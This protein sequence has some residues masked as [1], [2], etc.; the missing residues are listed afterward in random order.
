M[1]QACA[2]FGHH[3]QVSDMF[4]INFQAFR[5]GQGAGGLESWR[6]GELESWNNVAYR[7]VE[8]EFAIKGLAAAVRRDV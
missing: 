4:V 1:K 7:R 6:A 2:G 5:Q 8:C 3:E